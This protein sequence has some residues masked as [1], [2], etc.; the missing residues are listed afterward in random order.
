MR[1]KIIPII[2]TLISGLL[3]LLFFKFYVFIIEYF[4]VLFFYIQIFFKKNLNIKKNLLINN[5]NGIFYNFFNKLNFIKKLIFNGYYFNEIY[6]YY[7]FINK[8][9]SYILFKNLDKGIIEYMG[10]LSI[11]NNIKKILHFF[12]KKNKGRIDYI[13]FV[14]VLG[15][16][17]I[18][19]ILLLWNMIGNYKLIGMLLL[20]L[21]LEVIYN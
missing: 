14:M 16:I 12:S 18:N 21:L 6:N 13:V 5:N 7:V 9:L 1:I 10:H 15:I 3:S 11:V 20:L 4:Y 8:S 2:F 17:I 19:C